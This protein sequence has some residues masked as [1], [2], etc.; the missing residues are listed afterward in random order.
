MANVTE[1]G[2]EQLWLRYDKKADA[3]NGKYFE[4]APQ[5][6]GF[7]PENCVVRSALSELS[8]GVCGMLGMQVQA[9]NVATAASADQA[10]NGATAAAGVDQAGNSA[11][12]A[13]A[14]GEQG[15]TS[16]S[17]A[18]LVLKKVPEGTLTESGKALKAQVDQRE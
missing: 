1:N 10:G 12:G 3:G 5:L 17:Q 2:W 15:K 18:G 8:R 6:V 7:D 11:T 9:C 13:S 4:A 14:A 16:G